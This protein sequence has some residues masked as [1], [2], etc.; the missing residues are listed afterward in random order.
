[1]IRYFDLD[2][3][4][5]LNFH[6]F[7]Q[8]LLPCDDAYLRAAV[9]Q[10][11]NNDLPRNE[12][13][14]MRVERALS[15]LIF[16]EVR[17]HLKADLM[18]RNLENAY[19]YSQEKAF[20]AIDDWSYG[21]IDKSNLK[22]FLRSMGHLATK[23]ELISILR[24]FDMDGD[25]KIN[26]AEFSL[27]M[28]SSLTVFGK[29][30]KRPKSGNALGGHPS[31]VNFTAAGSAKGIRLKQSGT[32]R[33]SAAGATPRSHASNPSV[34]RTKLKRGG[35]RPKSG[36]PGRYLQSYE[37]SYLP[38]SSSRGAV[39]HSSV[40]SP[41]NLNKSVSFSQKVKV[42]EF[43]S[44]SRMQTFQPMHEREGFFSPQ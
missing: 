17:M 29:N 30:G 10:R 35:A 5:L 16:K 36:R 44:N 1:M 42:R 14:P 31:R 43:P 6:D 20:R 28:K 40:H 13:L 41:S 33:R 26:L 12:L 25:A 38:R 8:I 23:Q 27:G 4:R 21:Y 24:R 22:R 15:Q 7:L 3:D 2:G 34:R 39:Q 11:P 18:K 32:P 9:T 19:D 37:G